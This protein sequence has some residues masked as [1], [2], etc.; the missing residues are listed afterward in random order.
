MAEHREAVLPQTFASRH[1]HPPRMS[2]LERLKYRFISEQWEHE[3][4]Y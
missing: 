2:G 3:G 1:P 4:L